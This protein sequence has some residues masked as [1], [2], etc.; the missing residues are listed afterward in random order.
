[1]T[2]LLQSGVVF[3]H[4]PSALNVQGAI[5]QSNDSRLIKIDSGMAPEAGSHAGNVLVFEN[6]TEMTGAS[7]PHVSA[8]ASGSST[9]V[10]I[11]QEVPGPSKFPDDE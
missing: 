3:G 8:I 2:P 9:H 5:A 4:Q 1:L 7:A 6:P 10:A 11:Q